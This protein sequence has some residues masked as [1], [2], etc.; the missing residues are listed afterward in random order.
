[1]VSLYCVIQS[2]FVLLA[3]DRLHEKERSAKANKHDVLESPWVMGVVNYTL[4]RW[5]RHGWLK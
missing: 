2:A 5:S 1:M 3:S 4:Q